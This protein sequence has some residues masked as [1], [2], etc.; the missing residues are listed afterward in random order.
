MVTT[1]DGS[2]QRVTSQPLSPPQSAPVATAAQSISGR[3]APACM[4]RP[5]ASEASAMVAAIERSISPDTTSS[6]IAS[7]IRAFS[8]KL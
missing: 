5:M 3:L 6:A 8:E 1:M 4:A 2:F 7:A